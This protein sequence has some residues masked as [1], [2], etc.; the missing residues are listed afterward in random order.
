LIE[1]LVAVAVM[2]FGVA[3]TLRVFG[4]ADR[5]TLQAQQHE[6][7]VQQAQGEV[8]R[9]AS[10]SY[11]DLALTSTPVYSSDAADPNHRVSGTNFAVRA[12]LAEPLVTTP[13]DG[14]TARVAPGP[15]SFTVGTGGAAVTGRIYRYVTWRDEPCPA[16]TGLCDGAQN[17]KR[18]IVAVTVDPIPG[19]KPRDPI[20]MSTVLIDPAAAGFTN[21][22]AGGTGPDTSAQLFYLYDTP[23]SFTT[24]LTPALSH[25]TRNTA[26]TSTLATNY[27]TCQ[28][29]D[30]TKNPD[31]MWTTAPDEITPPLFT[32]SIDLVGSY[33][34]GLAMMRSETSCRRSYP[35]ADATNT[36]VANQWSVHAWAT[37][38]FSA[39]F[40]LDAR[41]TLSIHTQAVGGVSAAGKVCATLVDRVESGGKATDTV[42]TSATHDVSSWPATLRRLRFTT[43]LSSPYTIPS[44]HRLVLALH[45]RSESGA[46]LALMYDHPDHP[47][48]IEVETSTPL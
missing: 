37:N 6:V 48:L 1:V 12:D 22:G 3:A 44:G 35:A 7:A 47:S 29:P 39:P 26:A 45:V 28:N 38:Q 42:I 10:L 4:S 16:G 33:T 19:G 21:S 36:A 11:G 15:Q 17:T 31:L 27:S 2:S 34:A 32:Y 9:L 40:T 5:A 43:S 18:V 25:A 46:D 8:D 30:P 13:A 23:C 24:R 41:L 14:S 20:W